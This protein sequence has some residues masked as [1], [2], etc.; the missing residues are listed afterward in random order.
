[1]KPRLLLLPAL[2]VALAF[3]LI[4]RQL[5]DDARPSFVFAAVVLMKMLA[6]YGCATAAARFTKGDYLHT[7]WLLQACNY[8]LLAFKDVLFGSLLT[9]TGAPPVTG[10]MATGRVALVLIANVS[11]VVSIVMMARAWQ[12]AGIE[13]PGSKAVQR[14]VLL[15]AL[16]I[17]LAVAGKALIGDWQ[18][19]RAGEVRAAGAVVSLVADVITFTLI[20]PVMLTA[21]A[22]RGGLLAWPWGLLTASNLA[23][24]AYDATVNFGPL[25]TASSPGLLAVQN[26]WRCVACALVFSAGLAQRH[27]TRPV[28]PAVPAF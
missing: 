19:F 24:L 3:W 20:A 27:A 11:A 28:F 26:F 23:W 14:L 4:Q 16:G 13:L 15:I 21:I 6:L 8:G 10:A 7:A 25:L 18:A 2:T 12:V 9:S 1:M 17:A 22:L 5:G